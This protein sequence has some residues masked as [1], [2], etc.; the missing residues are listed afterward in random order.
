[1]NINYHYLIMSQKDLLQNQVIE[2][3]LREKSS[4][5]VSQNKIPDYWIL[6]S[7]NFIKDKNLDTK[8]K[9]TRFFENQKNKIVFNSNQNKGI[10]FYASLV[11]LD[12]EFMNWIK[13]RLGYFEEIESFETEKSNGFYVS[14]GICGSYNFE[15]KDKNKASFLLDDINFIHPDIINE[16]LVDSIKNFY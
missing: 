9:N 4:Y 13:L 16:K 3:I 11:S 2:E 14:D 6:I 15:E 1:M 10:E 12:K 5:Y 7:P 8:I